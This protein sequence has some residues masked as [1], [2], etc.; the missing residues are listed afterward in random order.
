LLLLV[1]FRNWRNRADHSVPA[2]FDTIGRMGPGAVFVLAVG[3]ACF[4]PKNLIML[5]AAGT[6]A[7]AVG[8]TTSAIVGG[9]VLFMLVATLPF[10]V[11]VG[12]MVF[13][14]A[15]ASEQLER[16]REWL[17]S[18]NRMIM[19]V[20]LGVLALVLISKGLTAL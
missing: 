2:V 7:G 14:G 1:A 3:V 5:L 20:V 6:E 10:S 19:A 9:L 4:N 16:A 15:S 18:R 8:D 17:T 12:Y 13:G 11:A